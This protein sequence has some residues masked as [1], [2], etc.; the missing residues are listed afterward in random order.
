MDLTTIE[1]DPAEARQH[2]DELEAHRKHLTPEEESFLDGYRA[3]ATGRPI[4]NLPETIAAGGCFDDKYALPRLAVARAY[5]PWVH[6]DRAVDGSLGFFTSNNSRATRVF[7]ASRLL[8]KLDREAGE[9]ETWLSSWSVGKRAIVPPVPIGTRMRL[10]APHR[11]G[12][13]PCFTLFEVGEWE[14]A[15]R[16]PGDPA[17]LRHI[18]G[19]LYVVEATWDLTDLERAVLAGAR[20]A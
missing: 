12:W 11:G 8:R 5:D 13:R 6:V 10:G 1:M 3:L 9:C 19:E 18:G 14:A 7:Y 2:A 17:L 15:P 20:I 4:I 16:P